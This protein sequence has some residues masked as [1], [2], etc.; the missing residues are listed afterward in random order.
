VRKAT[1]V[2][3]NVNFYS[4][5]GLKLSGIVNVPEG[6]PSGT[7]FPAVVLC[8]G[9]G[10]SKQFLTPDV[11][12]S[13]AGAGYVTFRFDYRGFGES[14]GPVCRL[15]PMEQVED[16]RNAI[17]FVQQQ[18]EVEAGR[19]GLW[20]AATGGANVSYTAGIDAR[21]R[22]MVSVSGMA[23]LGS[24][25]RSLRRYWEWVEFLKMIEADR[26]ARVLTGS[27]RLIETKQV[28]V[29]DPATDA[30]ARGAPETPVSGRTGGTGR[31]VLTAE[32]AGAMVQF[33]PEAVVDRI[34]PRAA[35]WIVA[36]E[37]TLVPVEL[38]QRMYDRALE[39]KRLVVV[40]REEHHGLYSGRGFQQ[41]MGHS[42]E[43]FDARLKG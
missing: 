3:R 43:W 36:G 33:R 16:I 17:T 30:F 7:R 35:M 10:G 29:R 42:I 11:S 15:I 38:S 18:P 12:R 20:G 27:S 2:E 25:M 1:I 8:Q 40:E 32:S 23:D 13:L 24:W 14:E 19:I 5:P 28:I 9:P 4:G 21:V 41:T 34:S 6:G 22:C 31:G 39:P 37:D 26:V